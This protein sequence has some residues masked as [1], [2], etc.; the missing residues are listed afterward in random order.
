M[1]TLGMLMD[2]CLISGLSCGCLRKA[3]RYYIA[4]PRQCF[5]R[6]GSQPPTRQ[7]K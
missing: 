7:N 4:R 3:Q 6:D 5:Q 2:R 1:D